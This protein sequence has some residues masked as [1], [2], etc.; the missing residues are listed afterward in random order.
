MASRDFDRRTLMAG[1]ALAGAGLLL[2]GAVLAQRR[3][4]PAAMPL[5]GFTHGVASGEP[6][7][8]SMLFWTRYEGTGD[9]PVPLEVEISAD[10]R[11]ARAKVMGHALAEPARDWTARVEVKGLAPGRTYYYRFIGPG[12]NVRSVIGRTRTLPEGTPQSFRM[13]VFSCSNLPYGFFN[14]YAHAVA[15]DDIDLFVHLGDYI[16]EYPRGTYPSAAETVAG[17]VIEPAGEI[18]RKQDYWARYRGY[19]LDPDLQAMHAHAPAVTMW[20]DHEIANDAW[21]GGA[22]NHQPNEGDWAARVAAAKAAYQD[23]MPVSDDLWGKYEIGRW[24]RC[25]SWKR[26]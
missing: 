20:D 18:I 24:R 23:W 2:P 1:A 22:E 15:A 7:A 14:G 11:M 10:P 9:Q 13:G 25:T 26:A 4:Q 17:R 5:G 3:K 16:Y 6:S 21:K 19:R 12:K 8:T